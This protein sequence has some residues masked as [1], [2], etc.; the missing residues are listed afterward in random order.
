MR[1][2]STFAAPHV[3]PI[4]SAFFIGLQTHSYSTLRPIKPH[5]LGTLNCTCTHTCFTPYTDTHTHRALIYDR[6]P[7]TINSETVITRAPNFVHARAHT[8]AHN[9]TQNNTTP[10]VNVLQY[11][12]NHITHQHRALS[13]CA[14][15]RAQAHS[16]TLHGALR[17]R[18]RARCTAAFMII[19]RFCSSAHHGVYGGHMRTRYARAYAIAMKI[20][21]G[22]EEPSNTVHAAV[23][24]CVCVSVFI[25]LN[26]DGIGCASMSFPLCTYF[27]DGHLGP[28]VIA[29]V[30][31]FRP[32]TE[33]A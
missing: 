19:S 14:L 2:R 23:C 26:V 4:C 32:A 8:R 27:P 20:Y 15:A 13:V 21:Y 3:L 16:R 7:M 1:Q 22:D 9:N 28:H 17:T 11:L 10:P 33:F 18:A 5:L 31:A 29:V 6:N 12:V 30:V 25:R 24:V